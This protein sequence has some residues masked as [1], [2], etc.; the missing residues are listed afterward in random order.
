M[1]V[2]GDLSCHF[3]VFHHQTAYINI[4]KENKFAFYKYLDKLVET[5]GA[6]PLEKYEKKVQCCRGALAFSKPVKSQALIKDIK[7]AGLVG[8]VIRSQQLEDITKRT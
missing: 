2:A 8:R 5:M 6:E 4:L 7:S 3:L 1:E